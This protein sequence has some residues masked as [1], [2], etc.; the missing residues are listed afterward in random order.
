MIIVIDG[1]AGSG[2]S[3]TAKAVAKQCGLHYL[4]SGAFY[5]AVTLIYLNVGC[6]KESFFDE[7][8][9]T[10]LT[11]RYEDNVFK[12]FLNQQEVTRT[13]REQRVSDKV[14]EV[15]A[16]SHARSFV[17]TLLRDFVK[18]GNFI[19]DGRDLG[20]VVFPDADFKFFLTADLQKRAKRRLLEMQQ[21]GMDADFDDILQNLKERDMKDS[22][23]AEAPLKKADDAISIDTSSVTFDE[24]VRMIVDRISD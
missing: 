2:K 18:S 13:I 22:T 6:Q 8:E 24:Q 17:N 4:D 5:R 3:S 21:A 9:H 16:M 10:D 1:P 15:A 19:A 20:T 12:V 7:L 23:R 11:I 14:S